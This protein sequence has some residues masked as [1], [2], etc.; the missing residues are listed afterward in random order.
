VIEAA[1]GPVPHSAWVAIRYGPERSVAEIA[2]RPRRFAD[3]IEG[4]ALAEDAFHLRPPADP[5]VTTRASLGPFAHGVTLVCCDQ[6]RIGSLVVVLRD[7]GLGRFTAPDRIE[8]RAAAERIAHAV[9]RLPHAT[10]NATQTP[11][12]S[13][14][15]PALFTLNG[16]YEIESSWAPPEQSHERHGDPK[17]PRRLAPSLEDAVR[18]LSEDWDPSDQQT[19][20]AGSTLDGAYVIRAVPLQGVGGLRIGV[21]IEELRTRDRLASAAQF[22]LSARELD[23][24]A[25]LLEGRDT[26][27]VAAVLKIAATTATDHV[28]RMLVKTGS[29]NRV[30][31]VARALGWPRRTPT[32]PG[33]T[34]EAKP[35]DLGDERRP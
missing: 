4:I 19:L 6:S 20:R 10:P 22:G 1:L 7:E 15:Q 33:S 25:Q 12:R 17:G 9:A 31:L 14:T 24:L 8:L 5:V 3:K 30:E 18:R 26:R 21:T 27:E 23:V 35:G 11:V 32:R 16:D 13:R 2:A 34:G 29:R 28:K